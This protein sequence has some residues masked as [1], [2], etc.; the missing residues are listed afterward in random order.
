MLISD[1]DYLIHTLRLNYLRHV[2]D[3]F[4][5]RIITL[6]PQYSQNPYIRASGLAD[7]DAWPELNVPQ[8]PQMTVDE[9]FDSQ[10]FLGFNSSEAAGAS[11]SMVPRHRQGP[12]PAEPAGVFPGAT[13]LKYTQTIMPGSKR[14][15][16]AGM[17][18]SGRRSSAA[19][20][21]GTPGTAT[22]IDSKLH[23]IRSDSAPTPVSSSTQPRTSPMIAVE[24]DDGPG[25]EGEES[26]NVAAKRRSSGGSTV[27]QSLT[28]SKLREQEEPP[29]RVASPAPQVA[30]PSGQGNGHPTAAPSGTTTA[31]GAALSTTTPP[32]NAGDPNRPPLP[33]FAL[34]FA[35][36]AEMEARRRERMKARPVSEN[37]HGERKAGEGDAR[38]PPAP[39]AD[40]ET[41][42]PAVAEPCTAGSP[43]PVRPQY[44][45]RRPNRSYFSISPP[46]RVNPKSVTSPQSVA[47]SSEPSRPEPMS[48]MEQVSRQEPPAAPPTVNNR[49]TTS[50]PNL[51]TN[52]TAATTSPSPASH[53]VFAKLPVQRPQLKS[54][55]TAMLS[56]KNSVSDNPFT[57]LYAAMSGRAESASVTVRV[58][59]PESGG[60][61]AV[62]PLQLK[63]RKDA[64]VEEV[65]GFG[66]WTYWD[67]GVEPKLDAGL[68]GEGEEVEKKREVR[69]SA[70]GW[71]LRIAEMDGEVDEDFPALDRTRPISKFTFDDYAIC[72]ATL[73]Q[74]DQN[75]VLESKIVRRPSRLMI[76]KKSTDNN[77]KTNPAASAAATLAPPTIGA[78][79]TMMMTGGRTPNVSSAFP[80]QSGVAISTGPPIFL[81][82][83]IAATADMHYSTTV[84]AQ[85]EEYMADVL[86]RVC[87]RRRIDNAKE[88]ALVTGDMR[89]VI[90][91]DR[92]VASL[93]GKSDLVLVKR[94]LLDKL[95]IKDKRTV[96][97]SD[98]NASIFKRMSEVPTSGGA[99]DFTAAYKRFVVYRKL[100]MLVGRHERAL[101]I[102]GDYIHIMPAA[103]PGL[104]DTGKTASYHKKS[105]KAC[106]QSKKPPMTTIKLVVAR[107]S[108]N[109]TYDFE[110]ED[111][112][113]A[114][115]IVACIKNLKSTAV[116]RNSTV[117]QGL[118]R[119]PR[120]TTKQ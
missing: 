57:T 103:N 105:I 119:N 43:V 85:S 116:E 39:G 14:G 117:K 56:A 29:E 34:R 89:I 112:K 70:V 54:A 16:G 60:P 110:A 6:N 2:E 81:R 93:A 73:T 91:L 92:T 71:N 111:A 33:P 18:V 23:R 58:W 19:S 52:T 8:S 95:G 27:M 68:E 11:S 21:S 10:N 51:G 88:W 7:K 53:S 9:G 31:T 74:V 35:R 25:E 84:N 69:L 100:P 63:V 41:N 13:G 104:L 109:K 83:R 72:A 96:R 1:P 108:G 47:T 66:L 86:E 75:R 90:P 42:G 78:G 12:Q 82:V 24:D 114:A 62:E 44:A 98:P 94:A 5:P 59:F 20:R 67:E 38:E 99:L 37:H 107:D 48:V 77:N 46:E 101:A 28:M 97:S 106:K 49:E 3:P 45:N 113:K 80:S 40:A 102:D 36:Q 115:E 26:S 76:A 50:S 87:R 64:T 120:R 15:V 32:E 30:P 79:T 4:G 118:G 17:R 22:A 65:I 55:L 61:A